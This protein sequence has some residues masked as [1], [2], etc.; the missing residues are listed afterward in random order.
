MIFATDVYYRDNKAVAAGVLFNDWE[1]H[2]PVSELIVQIDNVTE[3]E[4]GQFYKR[5]LPCIL[6]LLKQL[7]C[8][9]TYII[10]DGYVYLDDAKK[11]GLGKRL[12]DAL[13]AKSVVIGVAKSRF[14]DISDKSEIFR[15]ASQKPLYVTAVGI[16]ESEAKDLISRMYGE[17]R[18]PAMLKLADSL[19]RQTR[20]A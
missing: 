8:L 18:I 17:H 12:Y 9:P 11:P 2:E 15:G 4:P 16:N 3:Y 1:D 5:E 7:K 14:K 19:S 13:Q 10:V 20:A 6:E